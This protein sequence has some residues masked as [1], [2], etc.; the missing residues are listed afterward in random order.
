[1]LS[2]WLS[3]SCCDG[4]KVWSG[5]KFE[6]CVA[7]ADASPNIV[8]VGLNCTAPVFAEQL[9]RKAS[10]VT[11]KPLVCY[12]NSGEL[13]DSPFPY[14]D[15]RQRAGKVHSV[16]CHLES[17]RG[18]RLIG[19]CCRTSPADIRFLADLLAPTAGL[20]FSR[21]NFPDAKGAGLQ[22]ESGPQIGICSGQSGSYLGPLRKQVGQK[23]RQI[24]FAQVHRVGFWHDAGSVARPRYG[25][26]GSV[27]LMYKYMAGPAKTQ[28]FRPPEPQY[29]RSQATSV[30][31]R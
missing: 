22:V 10:R 30:P 3:F 26:F 5:E 21:T 25:P 9:L 27:M 15:L 11:A 1:M 16:G 24:L 4:E 13:W 14:M 2:A 28:L 7:L 20:V 29:R 6:D 18:A 12:P 31:R 23:V 17:L 19:G 8:A